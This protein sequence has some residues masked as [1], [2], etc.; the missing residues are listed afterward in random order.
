M[1]TAQH[2]ISEVIWMKEVMR[3]NDWSSPQAKVCISSQPSRRKN[4]TA[5]SGSFLCIFAL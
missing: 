2:M 4:S 5:Y 1:L 3:S